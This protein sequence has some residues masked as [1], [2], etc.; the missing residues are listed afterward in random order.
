MID[1]GGVR[2]YGQSARRYGTLLR[3]VPVFIVSDDAIGA[4]DELLEIRRKG[5]DAA[6]MLLLEE[7]RVDISRRAAADVYRQIPS[8]DV[9]RPYMEAIEHGTLDVHGRKLLDLCVYDPTRMAHLRQLLALAGTLVVRSFED[10]R[11]IRAHVG[12]V[13]CN[14]VPWL[15]ERELPSFTPS[16]GDSIVLWGAD[17]PGELAA[18]A[19]FALDQSHREVVIVTASPPGFPTQFRW[20][21]PGDPKIAHVLE[22]AA[23]IV[24]LT[25]D[26]PSWTYAFTRCGLPVAAASTS[27]AI[28]VLE[29]IATYEPWSFRS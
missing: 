21:S 24:D 22:T 26:D 19:A 23:C 16:R 29:G 6:V 17:Y 25:A 12:P 13:R 18:I 20:V 8:Y 11:R 15:P 28:E 5:A 10:L 14:V 4:R 2:E 1:T 9:R 27:G 7:P 3:G